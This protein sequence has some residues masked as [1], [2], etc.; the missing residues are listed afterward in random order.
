MF[1]IHGWTSVT[2]SLGK[3][4]QSE[5]TILAIDNAI[6]RAKKKEG[7][8]I[9]FTEKAIHTMDKRPFSHPA[10]CGST[11]YYVIVST[12]RFKLSTINYNGE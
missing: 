11:F 4:K 7:H 3:K 5:N 6:K 10:C 8:K 9:Y 12:F 1:T 2:S